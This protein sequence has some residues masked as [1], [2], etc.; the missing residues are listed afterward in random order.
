MFLR[1]LYASVKR[2]W[3]VMV[4][5][6]LLTAAASV[7]GY[8][9][10]PV[11]YEA[12]G[13]VALIPPPTA[14]ISGDNPFLYMGGLEQALGVLTVKLNSP[15]VQRPIAETYPDVQYTTTRD[16][17]TNGP[18][19]LISVTGSSSEDTLGALR[20]VLDAVPDT[21]A[22]L[23]DALDLSPG[24]RMT[25][26]PLAMDEQAEVS[27]ST[28]TRMLLALA[29]LGSAGSLLVAGQFDKVILRRRARRSDRQSI[30]SDEN[31]ASPAGIGNI[32]AQDAS[33]IR[34][35]EHTLLQAPGDAKREP[36]YAH[37]R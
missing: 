34:L 30:K 9:E 31:G 3:Y 28:R 26:M 24:A 10:A 37:R 25:S 4:V 12:S 11:K 17:S 14:V 16:S 13:S 23:Q 21:L 22:S 15:A 6:L 5:G 18:I 20:Y 33:T 8:Q 27:D 29:A 2:R 36:L 1:D 32:S 7:Y 19:V 35:P